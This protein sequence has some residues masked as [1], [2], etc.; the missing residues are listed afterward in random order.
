VTSYCINL[1]LSNFNSTSRVGG[2]GF[3]VETLSSTAGRIGET[4][5]LAMRLFLEGLTRS[6]I[7]SIILRAA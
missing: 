6:V 2:I 5:R 4:E 7:D 1:R 3:A